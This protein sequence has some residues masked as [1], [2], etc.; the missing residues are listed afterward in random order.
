M[1]HN[2]FIVM[3]VELF[4]STSEFFNLTVLW[5]DWVGINHCVSGNPS[6]GR[7]SSMT[8]FNLWQVARR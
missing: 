2:H 4:T 6:V 5:R 3:T 7:F 8:V 1:G